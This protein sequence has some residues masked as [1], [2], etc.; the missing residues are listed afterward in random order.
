M[1]I[2]LIL[3]V[4]LVQKIVL[5]MWIFICFQI[6]FLQVELGTN[7]FKLLLGIINLQMVLSTINQCTFMFLMEK[8]IQQE[9]F[10][11]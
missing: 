11:M 2:L 4:M 8:Q 1:G 10:I 7:T 9:I 6:L 5:L 3:F